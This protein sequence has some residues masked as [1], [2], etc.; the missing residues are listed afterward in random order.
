MTTEEDITTNTPQS[1]IE[2]QTFGLPS[3]GSVTLLGEDELTGRDLRVIRKAM[4]LDGAGTITNE[5]YARAMT[6]LITAWELPYRESL[7]IPSRL[8]DP[9]IAYELLKLTDLRTIERKVDAFLQ[10][11]TG[12]EKAAGDP[13][14]PAS[15]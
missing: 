15:A 12:R 3:G 9:N 10:E 7:D 14:P 6:A 2:A 4:D 5:L 1:L 11:I 8:K 13:Q